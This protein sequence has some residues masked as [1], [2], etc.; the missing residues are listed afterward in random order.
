MNK[1]FCGKKITVVL[2]L[3]GF[4]LSM[5]G[6]DNDTNAV[7]LKDNIEQI[8]GIDDYSPSNELAKSFADGVLYEI[9]EITWEHDVGTAEVVVTTPDLSIIISSSINKA[10]EECGDEDYNALLKRA[11]ELVA[12]T[13]NSN[14]YPVV[15]KTVEMEAVKRDDEV[16]IVSNDAFEKAIAGNLEELFI[17][18]LTEGYTNEAAN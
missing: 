11:K 3:I 16:L 2:L 12:E 13:M 9:K 5:T 1:I 8:Q 17:Q 18:V 6:C 10:L 7:K 15:E 4:I 14:S